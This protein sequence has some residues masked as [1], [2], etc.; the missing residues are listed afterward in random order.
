MAPIASMHLQRVIDCTTANFSRFLIYQSFLC[1]SSISNSIGGKPEKLHLTNVNLAA[2]I[3]WIL[4]VRQRTYVDRYA[5]RLFHFPS[6][7]RVR[8]TFQRCLDFILTR[9]L[10]SVYWSKTVRRRFLLNY[11]ARV[12][13][14]VE[15]QW[16]SN[17]TLLL[18]S[19]YFQCN[20]RM[21]LISLLRDSSRRLSLMES[22]KYLLCLINVPDRI[23][24]TRTN[25]D[26]SNTIVQ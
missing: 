17:A 4:I 15:F 8:F 5:Q 22:L 24:R 25:S 14:S 16:N 3:K 18:A 10:H 6:I 12:G 20:S 19:I 9:I 2:V 23:E 11:S 13:L 7:P 1:C 21:N 26:R